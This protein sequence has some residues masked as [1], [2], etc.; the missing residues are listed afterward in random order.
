MVVCGIPTK[1]TVGGNY[2]E[3]LVSPNHGGQIWRQY[4]ASLGESSKS[5]QLIA[6]EHPSSYPAN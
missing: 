4:E 5:Y 1:Y 6:K 3:T 2:I